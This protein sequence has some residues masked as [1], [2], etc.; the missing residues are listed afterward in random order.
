MASYCNNSLHFEIIVLRVFQLAWITMYYATFKVKGD[1]V[2]KHVT[3][4]H[5]SWTHLF[6]SFMTYEIR[7]RLVS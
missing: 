2:I 7:L 5:F 1:L 6:V 4:A 3:Y